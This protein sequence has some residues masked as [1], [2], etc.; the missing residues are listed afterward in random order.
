MN[1]ISVYRGKKGLTQSQLAQLCGVSRNTIIN[2]E[3]DSCEKNIKVLKK[4]ALVLDTSIFKIADLDILKEKPTN[5]EDCDYL[6][7]LLKKEYGC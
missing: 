1:L 7:E 3:N 5:K 6:I 2:Y 4:I